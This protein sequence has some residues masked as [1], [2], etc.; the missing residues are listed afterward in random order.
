MTSHGPWW[1]QARVAGQVGRYHHLP[2]P[3]QAE[4]FPSRQWSVWRHPPIKPLP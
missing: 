4:P 2:V 1:G 3:V